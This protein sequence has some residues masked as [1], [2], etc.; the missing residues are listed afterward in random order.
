MKQ[1]ES[2]ANEVKHDDPGEVMAQLE[3]L[4]WMLGQAHVF[5]TINEKHTHGLYCIISMI[6]ANAESMIAKLE[7]AA[8]RSKT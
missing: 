5:G 8:Q 1:E 4:G 7:A 2:K 3:A 6:R